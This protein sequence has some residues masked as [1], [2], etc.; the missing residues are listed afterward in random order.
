MRRAKKPAKKP[1]TVKMDDGSDMPLTPENLMGVVAGAFISKRYGL[2]F[3]LMVCAEEFV[4]GGGA[5]G[6]EPGWEARC[7]RPR[8]GEPPAIGSPILDPSTSAEAES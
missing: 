3:R 4:E 6:D 7:F 2:A 1:P 5:I 8:P